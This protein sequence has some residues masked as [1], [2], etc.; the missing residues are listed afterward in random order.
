MSEDAPQG[1]DG[2]K[3]ASV[4]VQ[5]KSRLNHTAQHSA[6]ATAPQ[7]PAG[8]GPEDT[9]TLTWTCSGVKLIGSRS[10]AE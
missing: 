9:Q 2:G 10:S 5:G 1:I 4:A 6:A 7:Q 8:P 3:D